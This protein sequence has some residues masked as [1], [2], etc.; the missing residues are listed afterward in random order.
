MTIRQSGLIDLFEGKIWWESTFIYFN[1][2]THAKFL[3]FL[4]FPF[5]IVLIL[6]SQNECTNS[7]TRVFV[8][9][10]QLV[11]CCLL[12]GTSSTMFLLMDSSQIIDNK[13]KSF[14]PSPPNLR[15]N[16]RKL[17]TKQEEDFS[18]TDQFCL[19]WSF[20]PTFLMLNIHFIE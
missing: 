19:L 3:S 2:A 14:F 18:S 7:T 12:K 10:C 6:S 9:R 15:G 11:D 16:K 4:I 5:F 1:H 8:I 17:E 20:H 13:R